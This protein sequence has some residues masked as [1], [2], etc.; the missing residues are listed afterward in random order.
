LVGGRGREC[1]G[2]RRFSLSFP[3]GRGGSEG[4]SGKRLPDRAVRA[5]RVWEEEERGGEEEWVPGA[6]L[7]DAN[8][9]CG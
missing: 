1:E 7:S 4:G 2:E 5:M 9:V 3:R 6:S 8:H